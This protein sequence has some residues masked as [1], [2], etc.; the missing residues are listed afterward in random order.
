VEVSERLRNAENGSPPVRVLLIEDDEDDFVLVKNLLVDASSSKYEI[1]WVSSYQEGL[2]AIRKAEFDVCLLD[3]RLGERTG[4]DILKGLDGKDLRS[5][6]ILLTGC[7]DYEIDID[8]MKAG[9]S[10]YLIKAEINSSLLDRSIR[11]ALGRKKTET[12][13]KE[14]AAKLEKSNRD[15]SQALDELHVLDDALKARNRELAEAQK[16]TLEEC[17][18]YTDL[19][20]YAP[21]GLIVTD[22]NGT[23]KEANYAASGILGAGEAFTVG[24]PL[25]T[26]VSEGDQREFR[27]QLKH[28]E[29]LD[30]VHD[31]QLR[32]K[33]LYGRAFYAEVNVTAVRPRRDEGVTLR[34]CIRDISERKR[35]EEELRKYRNRLEKIVETRTAELNRAKEDAERRARELD[36]AINSIADG[37]MIFDQEKKL[38]RINSMAQ[39]LL[40]YTPTRQK[41]SIRERIEPLRIRTTEGKEIPLDEIPVMRAFRGETVLCE[42]LIVDPRED[43]KPRCISFSSAPI[44]TPD[45]RFL[46]AITTFTDVTQRRELEAQQEELL[47]QIQ[48]Y[49]IELKSAYDK[50]KRQAQI[51]SLQKEELRKARDELELK[52]KERTAE[53][54]EANKA[55]YDSE[56]QLR[57]LSSRLLTAQ[58]EER[59]RL[60]RELHDSIGS[61][62]SGIKFMVE[63][64]LNGANMGESDRAAQSLEK[65]VPVVQSSI[66]EARRI[67]MGLRP[68]VL[69]DFGIVATIG[70]FYRQ[71]QETYPTHY[72]EHEIAVEEEDIPDGLKIILFRIVQE[73]FNNI[74]KYSQAELVCLSLKKSGNTIELI[75]EDNGLGFDPDDLCMKNGFESGLGL[76]SMK[77]RTELSGG[78][79]I[80]EACPGEGVT[81]K[82]VWPLNDPTNSL[83]SKVSQSV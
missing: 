20:N 66:D 38:T 69:D 70:W 62:L 5:P 53:L 25:L 27:A 42:P 33:P 43:A 75:I 52:V 18:R 47:E 34:W 7:R 8:A 39:Y 67:Y 40:G 11:Y 65:L 32:I 36:A 57:L 50:L 81:I 6:I 28:L 4:L 59:K 23:I 14:Y 55:L 46:G 19:F 80:L 37:V 48:A 44:R 77:E 29:Y 12:K 41:L 1:K 10:D 35:T 26:F 56:K 22:E 13:L 64:A 45:G 82:A 71:F 31:W 49:A 61:S 51:L 78:A 15:L 79:F 83:A 72:V 54:I 16:Q 9:A 63:N 68:S 76:S 30:G 73:A 17:D 58:E 74:A 60:A 2:Q 21:D 3:Y 24:K